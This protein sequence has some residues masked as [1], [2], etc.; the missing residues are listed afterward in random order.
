MPIE[1]YIPCKEQDAKCDEWFDWSCEK[2][3][4]TLRDLYQVCSQVNQQLDLKDKIPPQMG[5]G[6][7]TSHECLITA[8]LPT[9]LNRIKRRVEAGES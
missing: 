8:W 4:I 2:K 3:N 5:G 6:D 9:I 7:L 1:I